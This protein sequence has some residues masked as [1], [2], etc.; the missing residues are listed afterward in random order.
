MYRIDFII[1]VQIGVGWTGSLSAQQL[2]PA[3]QVRGKDFSIDKTTDR[4]LA[5]LFPTEDSVGVVG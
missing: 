2:G 3:F 4:Y 5:L 1:D